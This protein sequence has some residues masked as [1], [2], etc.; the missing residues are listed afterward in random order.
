MCSDG[1]LEEGKYEQHATAFPNKQE[2][3]FKL[4]VS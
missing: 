2:S 1:V 4:K 3:L